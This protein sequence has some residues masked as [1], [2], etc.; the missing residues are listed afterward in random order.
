MKEWL[1]FDFFALGVI[2]PLQHDGLRSLNV[3]LT[4]AIDILEEV[5][6]AGKH[7]VASIVVVLGTLAQ[8]T[9]VGLRQRALL[10]YT[11]R[12]LASVSDDN[13]LL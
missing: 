2:I 4:L 3:M 9:E 12:W 1:G 11:V 10:S 5:K 13:V 7:Q 6:A 8:V